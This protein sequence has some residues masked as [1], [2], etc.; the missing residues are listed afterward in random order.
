MHARLVDEALLFA[1]I[2]A[3]VLRRGRVPHQPLHVCEKDAG[4]A[5]E[6]SSSS[7][8]GAGLGALVM[9]AAEGVADGVT[10]GVRAASVPFDQNHY[11]SRPSI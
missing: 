2:D 1:N 6:T 7:G 8:G 5:P 4:S 11:A 9:R 10:R 3:V